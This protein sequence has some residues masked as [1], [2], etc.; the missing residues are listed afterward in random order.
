V[1]PKKIDAE[2]AS[3]MEKWREKH[4]YPV[5]QELEGAVG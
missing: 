5:R 2:L 4:G 1:L 3:F